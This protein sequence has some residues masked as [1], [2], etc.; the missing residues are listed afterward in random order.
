LQKK[1]IQIRDLRA[2]F[3]H[4]IRSR[5]Q[6]DFVIVEHHYRVDIFNSVTNYQ[7]KEFY[8]KLSPLLNIN[9]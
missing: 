7:S 8:S 5:L 4:I 1:L 3:L 6:K 9:N 2:S